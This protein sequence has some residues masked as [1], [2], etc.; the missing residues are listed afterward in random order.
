M[1]YDSVAN[2]SSILGLLFFLML[3]IVIVVWALRPRNKA[4]FDAA[5]RI[6][7][8]EPDPVDPQTKNLKP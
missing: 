5:A 3:F 4:R 1:S 6:P 7:L 8:E 2:A